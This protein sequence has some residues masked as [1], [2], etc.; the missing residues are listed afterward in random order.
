ML[1]LETW[2]VSEVFKESQGSL[3]ATLQERKGVFFF[4]LSILHVQTEK[5]SF[6]LQSLGCAGQKG[7]Y[8]RWMQ[9]EKIAFQEGLRWNFFIYFMQCYIFLNLTT[10]IFYLVDH[11]QF[12]SPLCET[13]FLNKN[14]NRDYDQR[15]P[16]ICF[17]FSIFILNVIQSIKGKSLCTLLKVF[18]KVIVLSKFSKMYF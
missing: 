13:L 9:T 5:D 12:S 17:L 18:V 11:L 14:S 16:N 15:R 10:H 3:E 7:C 6:F 8:N 4:L 1:L 2:T